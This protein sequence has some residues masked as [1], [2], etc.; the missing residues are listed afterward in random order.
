MFVF[1]FCTV[2]FLSKFFMDMYHFSQKSRIISFPQKTGYKYR[3][4]KGLTVV[5]LI[6]CDLMDCSPPGSPVHGILQ[7]RILD[8]VAMTFSRG[9]SC[10]RDRTQFPALQADSLLSEPPGEPIINYVKT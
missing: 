1:N 6:L 8:R 3:S 5:K 2:L 7:A 4:A 9:S 10:P